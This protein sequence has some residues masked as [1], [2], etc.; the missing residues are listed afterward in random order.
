MLVT[1]NDWFKVAHL[2][3]NLLIQSFIH[4]FYADF[5]CGKQYD[6]NISGMYTLSLVWLPVPRCPS[7]ACNELTTE[8]SNVGW[9]ILKVSCVEIEVWYQLVLHV[10]LDVLYYCVAVNF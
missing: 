5:C 8:S 1:S 6:G 3:I 7:S 9:S 4:Y 2:Y 10:A